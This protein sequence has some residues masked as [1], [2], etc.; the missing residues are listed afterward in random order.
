MLRQGEALEMPKLKPDLR[1]LG[2]TPQPLRSVRQ[3]GFVKPV[4]APPQLPVPAAAVPEP[5]IDVGPDGEYGAIENRWWR[6]RRPNLKAGMVI[7]ERPNAARLKVGRAEQ[8]KIGGLAVA[9]EWQ[10]QKGATSLAERIRRL[11][12]QRRAETPPHKPVVAMLKTQKIERGTP[13]VR[14]AA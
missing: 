5:A 1:I 13:T 4:S 10:A 14:A 9:R 3:T 6:P 7:L 8:H 11:L 2:R 12:Q